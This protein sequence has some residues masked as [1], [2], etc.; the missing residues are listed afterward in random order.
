MGGSVIG[1]WWLPARTDWVI[2]VVVRR[3]A[4]HL[5]FRLTGCRVCVVVLVVTAHGRAEH[6]VIDE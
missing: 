5:G 2:W 6:E 3:G 4:G 1:G